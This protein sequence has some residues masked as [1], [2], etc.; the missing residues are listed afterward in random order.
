MIAQEYDL[1]GENTEPEFDLDDADLHG[2]THLLVMQAVDSEGGVSAYSDPVPYNQEH[3][4]FVIHR[5]T[6]TG[7]ADSVRAKTG[8]TDPIP[9]GNIAA[10]IL[11][12]KTQIDLKLQSK[13]CATNNTTVK[14]DA[15]YYGLSEV[16][17]NIPDPPLQ[18]KPATKNH[19]IVKPDKDYYGLSEV[20]VEIPD[21]PLRPTVTIDTNNVHVTPKVSEEKE[22]Y[23]LTGVIVH[24]PEYN[25]AINGNG[26]EPI[27]YTHR[28]IDT[29]D[30]SI[31][32]P[33]PVRILRIQFSTPVDNQEY[34]TLVVSSGQIMYGLYTQ[35]DDGTWADEP[36]KY[37]IAY[38][39]TGGWR[40]L[41]SSAIKVTSFG[42][43]SYADR[44]WL[45]ANCRNEQVTTMFSLTSEY[46]ESEEAVPFNKEIVIPCKGKV[47]KS[48][49]VLHI[50]TI[51]D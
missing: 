6:I 14:P 2:G 23:G 15:G 28:F 36:Y 33:A 42:S 45:E 13:P 20:P 1:L 27:Q 25:G 32:Y 43:I 48:D 5:D 29:P 16:L 19:D 3:K 35:Y 34:N 8:K 39:S 38:T 11:S 7:I 12:M 50:K 24:L 41:N 26:V 9:T 47:M 30:V 37:N 40:S 18:S 51:F 10:E 44:G 21:P 49:I 17:V 4:K 31:P 22:Y 46:N